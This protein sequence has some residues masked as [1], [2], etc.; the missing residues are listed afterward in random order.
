MMNRERSH[1]TSAHTTRLVWLLASF[2]LGLAVVMLIMSGFTASR[3]N[4]KRHQLDAFRTQMA[5]LVAGLDRNLTYGNDVFTAPLNGKDGEQD[6]FY[7]IQ[8]IESLVSRIQGVAREVDVTL[9]WAAIH[10]QYEPLGVLYQQC[11][12]WNRLNTRLLLE[13]PACEKKVERSLGKLREALEKT[14]GQLRLQLAIKTRRLDNIQGPEAGQLAQEI[15]R[16]MSLPSSLALAKTE[17]ADLALLCEKL[18]KEEHIDHL[19]DIKDNHLKSTLERL[20][21]SLSQIELT[22]HGTLDVPMILLEGLKTE[23][24]GEGFAVN[25]AHQTIIPGKDALFSLTRD[26]LMQQSQKERLRVDVW[27][28]MRQLRVAAHQMNADIHVSTST[29]AATTDRALTHAWQVMLLL[30]L[31]ASGVFVFL[32]SRIARAVRD[33]LTAV[34]VANKESRSKAHALAEA[35]E[36]LHTEINERRQVQKSL[37]DERDLSESLIASLP[38]VFYLL[39]DQGRMVKQNNAFAQTVGYS[40]E[41]ISTMNALSFFAGSDKERVSER[42]NEVFT[43]GQSTVEADLVSRTGVATPHYLT[44]VRVTIEDTNY[45]VGVGIDITDRRSAEQKQADLLDKLQAVNDQLSHFAYVV[46][47]DLKAPLRGIKLLTEWLCTDYGDQ[48]G[49]EAKENF[50]LLQSRV[51]RMYNLIEGVLQY[52]RVGRIEEEKA[53]VDLNALLAGIID[54]IVPPE[55]V[56]ITV[57]GSLPSIECEPTRISQVFQ[58]LLTNAVKYMDKPVGEIVVAHEDTGGAW[59]FRVTDNGPGIEARHFDRIFKIFQTLTPRDEYESTGVGLTLVK[60]IV[61]L[62]GG[63]IWVESQVGTGSTFFF[64]VPK[65]DVEIQNKFMQTDAVARDEHAQETVATPQES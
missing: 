45:L 19:T 9:E 2:G 58:N 20:Q 22:E 61:E 57:E 37:K 59:Q 28:C 26:R 34:E 5:T 16:D 3:I 42:I 38:G 64:T 54:A 47:H 53:E 49:D 36:N 33:Q 4:T 43:S 35:N 11:V 25:Q 6:G 15:V 62:Y 60:K 17:L 46:S 44:G 8:A 29:L 31:T 1:A 65:H 23:L 39:D 27:G 13:L 30:C 7:W 24:F 56:T 63:T 12:D 18:A 21:R 52:S 55:H 40:C 14:E 48:L 41:Q 50:D 32:A 51:D 10:D